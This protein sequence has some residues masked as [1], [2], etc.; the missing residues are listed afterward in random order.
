M[1]GA[2]AL[3]VLLAPAA[4][5]LSGFGRRIGRHALTV[6]HEDEFGSRYPELANVPLAPFGRGLAIRSTSTA[7]S[8]RSP[9]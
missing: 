6:A 7:A 9:R 8:S 5:D 2:R 1:T 3:A 4:L